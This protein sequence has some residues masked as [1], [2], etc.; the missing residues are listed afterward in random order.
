MTK[1]IP[2]NTEFAA[3][4]KD[5][6]PVVHDK[7]VPSRK[8]KTVIIRQHKATAQ[9]KHKNAGVQLSDEFEA[10][11]PDHKPI[12]YV[13]TK[14]VNSSTLLERNKLEIATDTIEK[15]LIKKLKMGHIPPD[16]EIDLHGQTSQQ[17]KQEIIAVIFEAKKAAL[18]VYKH[19][20][21]AW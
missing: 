3:L 20:T 9:A 15:D 4:F 13:K 10:H 19:N 18:P 1:K 21:R 8:E 17:A 16:I 14:S 6:K 5:A 7:Y 2:A 12:S 11:W